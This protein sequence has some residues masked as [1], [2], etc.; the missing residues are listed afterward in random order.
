MV[1]SAKICAERKARVKVL[2]ELTSLSVCEITRKCN[3]LRSSIYRML[4]QTTNRKK[5]K[6]R[7]RP[8]KISEKDERH[9]AQTLI[10]LHKAEG[11]VSC[12]RVMSESE[13]DLSKISVWTA[14][15]ALNRLGYYYLVA[16]KKGLLCAKDLV[17]RS[18]FAKQMARTKPESFWTRDVCFYLNGVS[19]VHK[20]NPYSE[21]CAPSCRVWQKK[22]EGMTAGCTSKG[23]HVGSGGK[24]V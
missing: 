2:K 1:F 20:Y 21:S 16:R 14:R 13:V 11:T 6:S 17:Q 5:T 15:P 10:Q 23:T 19:F 4:K 3:I 12:S 18:R 9:I 24:T 22:N 8:R 7:G